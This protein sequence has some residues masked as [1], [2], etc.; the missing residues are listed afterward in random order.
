MS[1][2]DKTLPDYTPKQ[3]TALVWL[4]IFALIIVARAI[5]SCA[6]LTVL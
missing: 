5:G 3:L 6:M 4:C 1:N 2:H